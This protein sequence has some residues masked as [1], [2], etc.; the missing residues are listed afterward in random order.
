M[1]DDDYEWFRNNYQADAYAYGVINFHT[2]KHYR[3]ACRYGKIPYEY[4]TKQE[5]QFKLIHE[6]WK[7]P[8]PEMVIS[9]H[10]SSIIADLANGHAVGKMTKV[11][12]YKAAVS[13]RAWITTDGLN[14]GVSALI[15]QARNQMGKE[16]GDIV[17]IIGFPL[18]HDIK[19]K[20]DLENDKIEQGRA[21]EVNLSSK[22]GVYKPHHRKGSSNQLE[23]N[24][25][26]LLMYEHYCT[27]DSSRKSVD[28]H[29]RS[30]FRFHFEAHLRENG[31]KGDGIPVV[32]ILISGTLSDMQNVIRGLGE[33][34]P[35]VVSRGSGGASDVIALG[36][37]FIRDKLAEYRY[38]RY[39]EDK[40]VTDTNTS[41]RLGCSNNFFQKCCKRIRSRVPNETIPRLFSIPIPGPSREILSPFRLSRDEMAG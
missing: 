1:A 36:I 25:T 41:F 21:R 11:Q 12:V 6:N 20:E 23:P 10:G 39:G 27:Q 22:S 18:W 28:A 4:D 15:G 37:D 35:L 40:E 30:M 26:H 7:V 38:Q 34:I 31:R 24:H 19:N 3:A 17:P 9:L 8:V 29:R 33:E 32:N 2:R 13:T 16:L 5:C 14:G